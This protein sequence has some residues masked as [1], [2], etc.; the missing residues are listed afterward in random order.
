MRMLIMP[1]VIEPITIG[2][3]KRGLLKNGQLSCVSC[4]RASNSPSHERVLFPCT[5]NLL[6]IDE[7]KTKKNEQKSKFLERN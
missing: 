6:N 4:A 2:L 1:T 5:L 7:G 3:L